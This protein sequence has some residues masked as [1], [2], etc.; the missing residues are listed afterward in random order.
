MDMDSDMDMDTDMDMD[1]DM[2]TTMVEEVCEIRELIV[3]VGDCQSDSTYVI[4]INFGHANAANESFDVFLRE[5]ELISSNTLEDLPLRIEDFSPSGLEVDFIKIC[6]NDD[7]DCCQ[8]IEFMPPS[9]LNEDTTIEELCEISNLVAEVGECTSDSTYILEIN[10]EVANPDN[11]SFD[12]FVRGDQL[13]D[14]FPITDLPIRLDSFSA[15]G[16]D[17]DFIKVCVND[18]PDCCQEIEFLPSDCIE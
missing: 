5:D 1:S 14:F 10:F 11:E 18:N 8:E 16:L 17:F 2:D 13:I 7:P 4:D 3:E 15:S 6:I 12:L 9:C